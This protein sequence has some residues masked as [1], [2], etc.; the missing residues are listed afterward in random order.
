M[1]CT[2]CTTCGTGTP[3]GCKSNGGCATGGCNRLNTY[4]WLSSMDVVDTD[5][6][7]IVEVR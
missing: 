3:N 1:G 7:D 6:F 2:G 4:D 5:P